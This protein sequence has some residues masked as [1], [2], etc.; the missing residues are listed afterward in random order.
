M[1]SAF[2]IDLV[3]STLIIATDLLVIFTAIRSGEIRRQLVL[4]TIFL[5]MGMDILAHLNDT[6]HDFPSYILNEDIF[7]IRHSPDQGHSSNRILRNMER[8]KTPIPS[9]SKNIHISTAS[10][11]RYGDADAPEVSGH[12]TTGR[13]L[14]RSD[15]TAHGRCAFHTENER[16]TNAVIRLRL[17][18]TLSLEVDGKRPRGRPRQR[19]LDT[20]NEDMKTAQLRSEDALNRTKWRSS[21][22]TTDPTQRDHLK[23][24]DQKC[25]TTKNSTS[26]ISFYSHPMRPMVRPAV[27]AAC[28]F[29]YSFYCNILSSSISCYLYEEHSCNQ[30][31]S[32][33]GQCIAYK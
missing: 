31:F 5:A 19:W 25:S 17:H 9:S 21:I 22:R 6:I 26:G 32:Y 23:K 28:A 12:L 14:Q 24:R 18:L 8:T 29:P 1:D 16:K 33:Y 2:M 3:V 10:F 20:I 30:P 7:K 4:Y 13:R 15:S 27:C 11:L